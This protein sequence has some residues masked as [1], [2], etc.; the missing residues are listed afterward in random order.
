MPMYRGETAYPHNGHHIVI[1]LGELDHINE[2]SPS[3]L[4]KQARCAISHILLSPPR[5][6]HDT[7]TN[8]VCA[9]EL[10]QHPVETIPFLMIRFPDSC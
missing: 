5:Q 3:Q 4:R 7:L 6:V 10:D 2:A 8:R 9:P 1:V